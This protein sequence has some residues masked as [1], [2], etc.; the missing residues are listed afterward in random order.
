M[1]YNKCGDG[2]KSFLKLVF[3][4][5]ML[6]ITYI[7]RNDISSFIL[8]SVVYSNDNK[9]LTYNEYYLH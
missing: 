8:N 4:I 1:C 5:I 3:M 9:I 6:I 2:M 7:F